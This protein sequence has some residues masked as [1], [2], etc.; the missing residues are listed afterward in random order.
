[1]EKYI[2]DIYQ[3]SIF[4]INYKSLK[5]QGIRCL[6]FDLDN[7]IA[8]LNVPIPSHTVKDLF[9]Y[10]EGLKFKVILLSNSGKSRVTPFKE[11]LNIDASFHSGKPRRNKYQKILSMYHM[12]VHEVAA[13]GDQIFTDVW[14]ANRMGLT[15]ILVN[16]ISNKDHFITL[17]NRIFER[18]LYRKLE[19]KGILKRGSYYE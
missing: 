1:M 6:L 16:P 19:N 5:S 2:P 18:K 12:E 7:T 8:P 10:L 14:G 15:S 13:I 11:Q 3:K 4:T 9:A 17:L